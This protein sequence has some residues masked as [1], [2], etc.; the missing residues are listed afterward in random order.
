MAK[1]KKKTVFIIDDDPAQNDMLKSFLLEK[2]NVEVMAFTSGEEALRNLTWNPTIV[3]LDYFLDRI[4]NQA[5][6]GVE[7]LKQI[8]QQQPETYII[9][10][11]GQDKIEVAV[12]TIKY[13][14]VDYVVKNPT[15]FIR[16]E[17]IINQI[18][19]KIRTEYSLKAYRTST[20]VL[21][22]V[23]ILIIIVAIMLNQMGIATQNIGW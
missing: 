3:I 2:F 21:G 10:F 13:G 6:N 9:M 19:K 22:G 15:S 23:I 18:N 11:S 17:N 20:F 4:D 1:S 12:D 8:K 16:V 5:I 7:V 14:A